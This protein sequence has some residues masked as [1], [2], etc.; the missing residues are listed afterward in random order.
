MKKILT[1]TII[2]LFVLQSCNNDTEVIGITI[3]QTNAV[4][5]ANE[6][7]QLEVNVWPQ[8]ATNRDVIWESSN[9]AI[10]SV[11]AT[12]L[13][14]AHSIDG[15]A[16][17][18]ARTRSGNFVVT[19]TVTV[20]LDIF[21][22]ELNVADSTTLFV[23]NSL[24]LQAFILPTCPTTNTNVTWTSSNPT[25]AT[26]DAAGRVLSLRHG[27]TLITVTTEDGGHVA[28]TALTVPLHCNLETPGW[29][30]GLG[31]I[32]FA[33]DETW[34]FTNGTTTQIWSDAVTTTVCSNK[35]IFDGGTNEE[36][37]NADCRSLPGFR[38]DVFSW[39]A[40]YRFRD[41]LCPYPW[42]VPT[43]YDFINL[44]I[45]LGG[46]GTPA[47]N[48]ALRDRYLNDW[49]GELFIGNHMGRYWSISEFSANRLGSHTLAIMSNQLAESPP[50]FT[51]DPGATQP[52][53]DN[54]F[55]GGNLL[56]CVRDN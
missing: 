44:D 53:N 27:E 3:N 23:G 8:N 34:N 32:G 1:T 56:R 14:T 21:A 15:T 25:I 13:I 35:T 11:N 20:A 31:T 45:L 6:A 54:G 50:F 12:G 26:V 17:I 24:P 55:T 19:C 51:I 18:T 16:Y 37:F 49:G 39:C 28:T 29:G 10:A 36:P 33:T 47:F 43:R 4:L 52:K 22:V 42:R 9:P 38:G 48:P 7:F 40:V 2:L 5:C 30:Q 41:E 46:S